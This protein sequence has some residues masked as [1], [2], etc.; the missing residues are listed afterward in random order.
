MTPL[1]PL[2]P[3]MPVPEASFRTDTD[4]MDMINIRKRATHDKAI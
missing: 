4:E 3:Y 1:A 2:E